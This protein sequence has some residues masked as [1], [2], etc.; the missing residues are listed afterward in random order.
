MVVVLARPEQAVGGFG[1]W[2]GGGWAVIGCEWWWVG[3]GWVIRKV[4]G[5][6][7]VVIV[8]GRVLL[9]VVVV[10]GGGQNR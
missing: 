10:I 5:L 1:W 4:Y 7:L 9:G 2:N 3:C 6:Q 8:M